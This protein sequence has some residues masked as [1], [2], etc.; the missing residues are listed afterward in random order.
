MACATCNSFIIFPGKKAGKRK[1]CNQHCFDMDKLGRISDDVSDTDAISRANIIK[2][3]SCP[4][5]QQ[6]KALEIYKSYFVYSIILFTSWKTISELSCRSC[7]KKQQATNLT[8]SSLAGWWGFP[9]GL[10][11]T[12][13]IIGANIVALIKKTDQENTSKALIEYSRMSLAREIRD[14]YFRKLDEQEAL[15]NQ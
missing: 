1:Y 10:I 15:S 7:A 9:F 11:V 6:T 13:I 12:P 14:E 4:T 2:V 5:C 8:I 3:S